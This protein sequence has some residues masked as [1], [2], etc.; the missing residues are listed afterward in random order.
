MN[1]VAAIV[2]A[3]V[4]IGLLIAFLSGMAA[5]IGAGDD[6]YREYDDRDQE[7]YIRRWMEEKR[8]LDARK[9]TRH[10]KR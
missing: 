4:I 8:K 7:E 1:H 6:L 3:L 9:K 2:I 5:I 10:W